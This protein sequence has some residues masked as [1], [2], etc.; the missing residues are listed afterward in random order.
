MPMFFSLHIFNK[1]IYVS[2][3]LT[4]FWSFPPPYVRPLWPHI[5]KKKNNCTNT[6][7]C[8]PT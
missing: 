5:L 4:V 8:Y 7:L 3:G 2:F 1:F 6:S